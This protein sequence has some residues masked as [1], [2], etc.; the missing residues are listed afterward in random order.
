MKFE[1]FLDGEISL[2]SCP[3][4]EDQLAWLTRQSSLIL[5]SESSL[6]AVCSRLDT[7]YNYIQIWL[8]LQLLLD[9]AV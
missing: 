6:T 3:S 1:F 7:Q 4:S 2:F 8:T 5:Q 9:L